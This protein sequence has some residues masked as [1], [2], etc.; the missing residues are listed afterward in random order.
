M[1]DPLGQRLFFDAAVD[2]VIEGEHIT[3]RP[4]ACH[5]GAGEPRPG[6]LQQQIY[7]MRIRASG[8]SSTGVGQ[9]EAVRLKRESELRFVKTGHLQMPKSEP[10]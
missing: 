3:A 8:R 7:S 4:E 10:K 1:F 6:Q 9:E 5:S 2:V